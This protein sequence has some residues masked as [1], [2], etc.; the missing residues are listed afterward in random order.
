MVQLLRLI[1]FRLKE[2][3]MSGSRS[4]GSYV[5]IFLTTHSGS[6]S[7]VRPTSPSHAQK[8]RRLDRVGAPGRKAPCPLKKFDGFGLS[9]DCWWPCSLDGA[10]VVGLSGHTATFAIS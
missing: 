10:G 8:Q 4:P 3:N 5:L 2:R 7:I 9:P 1:I 6:N